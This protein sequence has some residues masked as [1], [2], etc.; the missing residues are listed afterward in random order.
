MKAK[1]LRLRFLIA[2]GFTVTFALTLAGLGLTLLFERHFERR[3]SSELDTYL[4]QIAAGVAFEADGV[5]RLDANLADPRFET[6]HSGLYWQVLDEG[7]QHYIRSRSLWDEKLVLPE[8]A[9]Y[10][11]KIDTH[12]IK[13]PR[14]KRLLVR[15]RRL[16][17]DRKVLRFA[18]AMDRASITSLTREF[19]L[20]VA[21]ALF[22]LAIILILAAW[23]QVNVGLKPLA[24]IQRGLG[25][26]RDGLV[27]RLNLDAPSEIAPLIEEVNGLLDAQDT[28]MQRARD[29]AADLAHG[30]KTPLTALLADVKRL[31]DRGEHEIADE[32]AEVAAQMHGQIDRELTRSR[33]R[34]VRTTASVEAGPALAHLIKTLKRTPQGERIDFTVEAGSQAKVRVLPDDLN[35]ILGN[36]LE[37]AVRHAR[38]KV[39]AT[40]VREGELVRF[41][42][43]DDGPGIPEAQLKMVAARGMRLDS[44]PTGSGLGLAIVRDV[45]DHYGQKLLLDHSKLGGLKVSFTLPA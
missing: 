13:G 44:S 33:I 1:S 18:V 43:E 28:A 36:I 35:E 10:I 31:H 25:A 4:N 17:Y 12:I 5:L 29:R 6:V 42:I 11:G 3:I 22:L 34:N 16:I 19:S 32:I 27:A 15:E 40:A 14:D 8:D 9:S 38:G 45:L 41:N 2:A 24:A 39:L 30:F 23:L 20:E 21:L 7:A 26:I 37:N